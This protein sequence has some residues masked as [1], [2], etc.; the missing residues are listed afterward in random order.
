MK[1]ISA[2]K[3]HEKKSA[4]KKCTKFI[5]EKIQCTKKIRGTKNVHEIYQREKNTAQKKI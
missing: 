1:K 5:H 3:T 4:K 2:Q